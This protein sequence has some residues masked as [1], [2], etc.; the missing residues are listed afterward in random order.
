M[1]PH[2]KHDFFSNSNFWQFINIQIV[3]RNMFQ[4][5]SIH[6]IYIG[7]N[8][9]LNLSTMTQNFEKFDKFAFKVYSHDFK[10]NLKSS[11]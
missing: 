3:L 7:R 9:R 2:K 11:Q 10:R 4:I 1:C 6:D 8:P 5:F